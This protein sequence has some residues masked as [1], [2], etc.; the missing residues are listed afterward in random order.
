MTIA[1]FGWLGDSKAIDYLPS[2]KVKAD[3]TKGFGMIYLEK[4]GTPHI[5]S[6]K[7]DKGKA[8]VEGKVW[9]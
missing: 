9:Q 3:W 6:I 7:I 8:F 1:N 2:V 5:Q 4:D